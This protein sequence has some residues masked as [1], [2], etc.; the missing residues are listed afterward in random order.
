MIIVAKILIRMW[1]LYLSSVGLLIA[2]N[3]SSSVAT[4][5]DVDGK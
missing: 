5:C 2:A 1:T 3:L 4:L